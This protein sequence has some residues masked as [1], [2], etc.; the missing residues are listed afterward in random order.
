MSRGHGSVQRGLIEI[1]RKL[2]RNAGSGLS[3]SDLVRRFYAVER[4]S[5][6]Q[7]LII[8]RSLIRLGEEGVLLSRADAAKGGLGHDRVWRINPRHKKRQTSAASASVPA[9]A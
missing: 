6:A 5:E 7:R 3:T 2:P 8:K 9:T 1:L 4:Y